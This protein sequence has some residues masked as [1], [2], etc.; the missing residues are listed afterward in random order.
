MRLEALEILRCPFCGGRLEQQDTESLERKGDEL[1]TGLLGCACCAYPV[2]AGIPYLRTGQTARSV[3][4]L[5]DKGQKDQALQMLLGL[6]DA[7]W[8]RFLSLR[9]TRSEFTYGA[10]LKILSPNPEGTYFLY[11]FS[12]PTFLVSDGL[13]CALGDKQVTGDGLMLDLCG[14]SGHLARTL[15]QLSQG[16]KVWLAD[17]E[18]WKLW[19]ARHF[20]APECH[21]VCCDASQSLPF[22]RQSFAL[23]LCSDALPYIWPRR[24][25]AGEMRRLTSPDGVVIATQ[26][27]N[28]FCQNPSE[29]SQLE[30][31]GWREIFEEVPARL[32]KESTVLDS[33]LERQAI[34][35]S[36]QNTDAELVAEPALIAISTRRLGLFREYRL[37]ETGQLLGRPAINPLYQSRYV[38]S[39]TVL[40]LSFPSSFYQSEFEACRRYLPDQV[41][42]PTEEYKTVRAGSL[43]GRWAQMARQRILLDLPAD[44]L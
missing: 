44:Y 13:L 32:F 24:S 37:P 43:H 14:G 7:Q 3:L 17:L 2:V 16:S 11:R 10:C 26:L 4:R 20:V 18:F 40:T 22:A 9:Q 29:G 15:C 36:I 30:P 25:L 34:D 5:L 35:L 21:A 28:S 33:I 23:A 41:E 19:L 39:N 1:Q 8:A 6:D 42:F 12:D 31:R 38:G 27:H